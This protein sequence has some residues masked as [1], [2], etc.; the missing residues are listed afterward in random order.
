[1]NSTWELKEKS[2]GVLTVTVEG[3]VWAKA[4]K[5]TLSKLANKANIPGFRQGKAP[6]SLIKK[7]FGEKAIQYEAAESIANKVLQEAVDANDLWLVARPELD[8]ESIDAEKVVFTFKCT[9]KP[10][11]TLGQ[12]K[13][14]DI[15]KDEVS[16]DENDIANELERL[17]N[18]FAELVLKEG[19][20][21]A[22]ENGD[23]TVIDFEGF[24]DGI[25]FE[26][27]KAEGHTLE[28]G[29]GSFIPGFEEKMLGMKVEETRDIELTFPEDY[30]AED[31]AGANV[32]FKV[33][34]HEI[35]GK[36]LPE[37]NDEL[38]KQAKVEGVET[39]EA[40]KEYASKT[41]LENR[42]K[43]A[44]ERFEEA[45]LTALC[46]NATVEIPQCMI[47]DETDQ[48][49]QQYVQRLT[50]QGLTM[51]QYFQFTGQNE[52]MLRSQ[53]SIDGAKRVEIRLILEAIA[54]AENI[55]VTAEELANE[56]QKLAD[57]YQM[58][59]NVIKGYI[60]EDNLSFDVAQMKAL[61]LVKGNVA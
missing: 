3:D 49:Y 32:V 5:S 28:I 55:E 24:R 16:V 35:K 26:G 31:L 2:T 30:H 14:L 18:R 23:T 61:D 44:A 13:G 6:I 25:P 27:G 36:V 17:Q 29:S 45:I 48:I 4:Q 39:V 12:Y 60:P 43:D 9:V 51:E 22:V 42:E 47:D 21:V 15:H 37:L 40:Y 11:V 54:K 50:S 56:Y 20:D 33:T 58:D 34:V 1:M 10:E 8:I 7:Q 46:E 57:M 59:V 19:E 53:M 38:V 41:L 52:E